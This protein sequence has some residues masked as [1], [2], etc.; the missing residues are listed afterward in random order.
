MKGINFDLV[1]F[2]MNTVLFGILLVMI[3]K[4]VFRSLMNICKSSKSSDSPAGNDELDG[5]VE[6]ERRRVLN[7][8]TNPKNDDLLTVTNLQKD[9]GKFKAVQGI[10]FGVHYGEC[11][12]FLG[13][14]GAGKTTSFKYVS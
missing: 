10:S 9:F 14:I 6:T 2:V 12:G 5:D 3:E 7:N 4:K 13:I 8:N 11:F 1:F